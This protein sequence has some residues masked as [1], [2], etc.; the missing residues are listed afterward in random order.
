LTLGMVSLLMVC[1]P[2]GFVGSLTG[3]GGASILV[4]ILVFFG[5]PIKEAI[6][7]G[8]ISVMPRRAGQRLRM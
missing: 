8:L 2:V 4:P 3:L 6:A 1:I 7:S 5:L